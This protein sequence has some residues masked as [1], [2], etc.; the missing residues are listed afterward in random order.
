MKYRITEKVLKADYHWLDEDLPVGLIVYGWNGPTY[1]CVS[2]K[3]IAVTLYE[4][5]NPFLEVPKTHLAV[6]T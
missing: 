5:K 1:G 6:V 4:D 2:S 3:G